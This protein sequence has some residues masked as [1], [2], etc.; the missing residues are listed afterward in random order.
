MKKISKSTK[1]SKDHT[2]NFP[3]KTDNI[4]RIHMKTNSQGNKIIVCFE[5][6]NGEQHVRNYGDIPSHSLLVQYESQ[7]F[8][9]YLD[10]EYQGQYKLLTATRDGFS[11]DKTE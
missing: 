9:Y 11:F 2:Y 10:G 3:P 1:R 5:L 6:P 4:F 8:E 7:A